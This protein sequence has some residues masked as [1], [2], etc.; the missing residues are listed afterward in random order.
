MEPGDGRVRRN[1]FSYGL[2][3]ATI[4]QSVLLRRQVPIKCLVL[5]DTLK[6]QFR[7]QNSLKTLTNLFRILLASSLKGVL[8]SRR[9]VFPNCL[10]KRLWTLRSRLHVRN[11]RPRSNVHLF[12][13]RRTKRS[14]ML[15]DTFSGISR[16]GDET[17]KKIR[18]DPTQYYTSS[19]WRVFKALANNSLIMTSRQLLL[20]MSN[21]HD[22]ISIGIILKSV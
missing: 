12:L 14:G 19:S 5:W 15:L 3:L 13:M 16:A 9:I 17:L 1:F 6:N 20:T 7:C 2:S 8:Y 10:L 21:P 11:L 18:N 4:A 22:I